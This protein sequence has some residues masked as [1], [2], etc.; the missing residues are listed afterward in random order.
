MKNFKDSFGE[1]GK[2]GLILPNI[3][4]SRCPGSAAAKF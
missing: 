1:N 4:L 2:T 3:T